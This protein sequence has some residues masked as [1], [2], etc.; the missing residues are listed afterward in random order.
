VASQWES[1]ADVVVDGKTGI[2]YPFGNVDALKDIL[3]DAT[4]DPDWIYRMK[5]NCLAYAKRY[6][7]EVGIDILL[8]QLV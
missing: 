2:V 3:M 7:P 8:S 6:L 1:C 5:K 4:A